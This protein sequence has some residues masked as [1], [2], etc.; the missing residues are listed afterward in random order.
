MDVLDSQKYSFSC[1]WFHQQIL[2]S[3]FCTNW[4]YWKHPVFSGEF[5]RTIHVD[6]YFS[7]VIFHPKDISDNSPFQGK[8]HFLFHWSSFATLHYILKKLPLY[9]TFWRNSTLIS[10]KKHCILHSEKKLH[11]CTLHS[12][13]LHHCTLHSEKNPPLY[14]TFWQKNYHCTVHSEEIIHCT[15]HS[16]KL[17]HCTLHSKK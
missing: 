7:C 4:C 17:H 5:V 12:E 11:H 8:M 2:L 13:K 14:T 6:F 16:E 3:Y 9:T 1:R 10:E 15:I